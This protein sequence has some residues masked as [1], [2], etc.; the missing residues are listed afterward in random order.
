MHKNASSEETQECI[1]LIREQADKD[2][3]NSDDNFGAVRVPADGE[4]GVLEAVLE[5]V[6]QGMKRDRKV[7]GLKQLQGERLSL[8]NKERLSDVLSKAW[9]GLAVISPAS[10][11]ARKSLCSDV[12]LPA[13]PTHTASIPMSRT[14]SSAGP[15]QRSRSSSTRR[16]ASRLSSSYSPTLTKAT[17]LP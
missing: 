7:T 4:P 3:A 16:A 10:W 8:H 17:C 6:R 12:E 11:K 2:I 5:N 1:K 15:P 14:P 9:F 13:D